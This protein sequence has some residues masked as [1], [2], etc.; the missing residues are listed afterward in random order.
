MEHL[1]TQHARSPEFIARHHEKRKID[2]KQT[3]DLNVRAK[4]MELSEENTEVNPYDLELS[5]SF[6]NMRAKALKGGGG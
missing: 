1:Y 4:T 5:N 2:P 3:V 6:L